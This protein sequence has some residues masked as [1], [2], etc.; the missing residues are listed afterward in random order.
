M[1][2]YKAAKSIY[3]SST[4]PV[5]AIR[6]TVEALFHFLHFPSTAMRS[7][8]FGKSRDVRVMGHM[9]ACEKHDERMGRV[10]FDWSSTERRLDRFAAVR[11][12]SC[13]PGARAPFDLRPSP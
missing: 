7:I 2:S 8:F 12:M 1:R 3:P 9:P 5:Q 13:A 4:A 10:L 11:C 6:P